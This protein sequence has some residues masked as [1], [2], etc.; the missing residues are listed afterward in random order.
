MYLDVIEKILISLLVILI[1]FSTFVVFK[2]FYE[3]TQREKE[4]KVLTDNE[5]CI[6]YY[7]YT[8]VA[9]TP[10]KCFKELNK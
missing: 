4:S 10:F 7:S 3:E 8:D 5:F 9:H 6:K 2:V 1:F